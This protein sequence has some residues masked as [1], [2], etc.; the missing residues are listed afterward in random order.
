ML[1][2]NRLPL[3]KQKHIMKELIETL[4][5]IDLDFYKGYYTIGERHDLIKEVNAVL[6]NKFF[7]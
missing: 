3:L 2:F 1:R 6:K 5:K 7:I 4:E